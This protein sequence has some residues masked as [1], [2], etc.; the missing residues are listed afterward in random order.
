MAV[1]MQA[2]FNILEN[3]VKARKRVQQWRANL[4]KGAVTLANFAGKKMSNVN[5][6]EMPK[7]QLTEKPLSNQAYFY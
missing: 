5:R 7:A 3:T 6:V 4:C 1:H 2:L